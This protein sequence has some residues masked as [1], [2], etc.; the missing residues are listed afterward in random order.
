LPEKSTLPAAEAIEIGPALPP[1]PP[2][3]PAV[4]VPPFARSVTPVAVTSSRASIRI[5]PAVQAATA[6]EQALPPPAVPSPALASTVTA[7]ITT[8]PAPAVTPADTPI[9]PPLPP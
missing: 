6:D 5:G 2:G 8:L 7:P 9:E 3:P 1:A 4:V